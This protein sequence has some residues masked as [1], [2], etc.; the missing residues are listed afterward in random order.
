MN[1]STFFLLLAGCLLATASAARIVSEDFNGQPSMK[2]LIERGRKSDIEDLPSMFSIRFKVNPSDYLD[3]EDAW[4]KLAKDVEDSE[5]NIDEFKL[6][7][8]M[9]D[10]LYYIGYGEWR[11]HLDMHDHI[12]SK[13]FD[14]FAKFVDDRDIKWELNELF[15][16]SEKI[17]EETRKR[18]QSEN[19]KGKNM[20]HALTVYMVPPYHQNKFEDAWTDTAKDTLKESGN[21]RY[22]L[23]KV[24]TDNTHYYTIGTWDSHRDF[25]YHQTSKHLGRLHDYVADKDI[26]WF[27]YPLETIGYARTR[28]S[29]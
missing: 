24:S 1:R 14:K 7:K 20:F 28:Y 12:M 2:S 4:L 11:D 26:V 17:D 27:V 16:L 13:H 22:S 29:E 3:F 21:I 25:M 8:I 23:R 6:F 19:R 10:N 9:T 15:D 5:K 18:G